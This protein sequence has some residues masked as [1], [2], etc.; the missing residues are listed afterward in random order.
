LISWRETPDWASL[1]L[2][3]EIKGWEMRTAATLS[4][5]VGVPLL[6]AAGALVALWRE[7]ETS[8]R[9]EV[10]A[11]LEADVVQTSIFAAGWDRYAAY[12]IPALVSHACA[13]GSST[14]R[15]C[16]YAFAEGRL[17]SAIDSGPIDIVMRR[18]YDGGRSWLPMEVVVSWRDRATTCGNPSPVW[19]GT[20]SSPHGSLVLVF[21][22]NNTWPFVTS[23]GS[24]GTWTL[25]RNVTRNVKQAGWG[26]IAT[27]PGHAIRL[28]GRRTSAANNSA[29][30]LGVRKN[31]SDFAQAAAGGLVAA[32]RL[33]VPVN[34][35]LFMADIQLTVQLR[36]ADGAHS[37]VDGRARPVAKVQFASFNPYNPSEVY[38]GDLDLTSWPQLPEYV[39][40]GGRAA[41]LLSD[42]GGASWRMGGAV[43]SANSNSNEASIAELD[44]GTL[45]I[46]FRIQS[47]S[48][49]EYGCRHFALSHDGGE[50]WGEPFQADG[51]A[52]PD[53]VCQGSILHVPRLGVLTSGP[54]SRTAR[55]T[56]SVHR[57]RVA[58]ASGL[59]SWSVV[60]R[61]NAGEAAYSDLAIIELHDM[62]DTARGGETGGSSAR[63]SRAAAQPAATIGVL[64]EIGNGPAGIVFARLPVRD[65]AD[66]QPAAGVIHD[67]DQGGDSPRHPMAHAGKGKAH[68]S[69][70]AS[71]TSSGDY[72]H[73][74]SSYS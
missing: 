71:S 56:M 5:L 45:A 51:C 13:P 44:D 42:D 62:A 49:R 30:A 15:E 25:P 28:R 32:G 40:G 24:D 37:I 23:L 12:R 41:A 70:A 1:S 68:P 61:L 66:S 17:E 67:L 34:R 46:S 2:I 57:A 52:V 43:P 26:W 55:Q 72:G 4:L 48:G 65:S 18:S 19:D 60:A 3:L 54:Q 22:V 29:L 64:Y 11:D 36:S 69:G 20:A 50:T 8:A 33:V 21:T 16:M 14:A 6:C 10:G 47:A 58:D 31:Q 73:G 63:T 35:R 39:L 59:H 27:G 53:P 38:S 74:H 7:R 9:L